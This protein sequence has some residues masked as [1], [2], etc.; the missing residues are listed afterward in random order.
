M[1]HPFGNASVSATDEDVKSSPFVGARLGDSDERFQLAY[2]CRYP[3]M[4]SVSWRP[5]PSTP[6]NLQPESSQWNDIGHPHIKCGYLE[7]AHNLR[8]HSER[9]TTSVPLIEVH[10]STHI[11]MLH[12]GQRQGVPFHEQFW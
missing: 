4:F 12:P 8:I 7:L 9:G 1:F 5:Q 10:L 11:Q 2:E 3:T 6:G